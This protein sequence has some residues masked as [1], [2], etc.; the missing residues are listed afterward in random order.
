MSTTT[1]SDDRTKTIT[2]S[3]GL[4]VYRVRRYYEPSLLEVTLRQVGNLDKDIISEVHYY[5]TVNGGLI[6][7]FVFE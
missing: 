5:S 6:E 1:T 3:R 2:I 7:R 4:R